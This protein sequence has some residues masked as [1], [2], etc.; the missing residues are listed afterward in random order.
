MSSGKLKKL[1]TVKELAELL[2]VAQSTIYAWTMRGEI[3]HYKFGKAIR[4]SEE[5]ILEWM[6]SHK[7]VNRKKKSLS[8]LTRKIRMGRDMGW[9]IRAG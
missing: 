2:N 5:E 1:L 7:Q 9:D 8:D 6:E 4:F 3:P